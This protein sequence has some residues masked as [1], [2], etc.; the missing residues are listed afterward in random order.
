MLPKEQIR[1]TIF[2]NFCCIFFLST[3]V[4]EAHSTMIKAQKAQ[5]EKWVEAELCFLQTVKKK[6]AL[7]VD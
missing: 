3:V 6:Y 2:Q 4:S 5:K 1:T 7:E